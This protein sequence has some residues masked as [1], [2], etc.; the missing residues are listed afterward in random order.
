[1]SLDLKKLERARA[2]ADGV[3]QARCPACAKEG[4]DKAGEHLRVYSDGR[5]GCCVHPR[6]R[7]HRR[8]IHALAGD[9]E[10][11]AFR[12][13][14][15]APARPPLPLQSVTASLADF[16]R[17]LRTADSESVQKPQSPNNEVR[18]VRTPDAES[19]S[20]RQKVQE[21]FRTLRTGILRSRAY[22][23]EEN[24]HI[25]NGTHMCKDNE[26]GVLSVLSSQTGEKLP[27][28]LADGTLVI[29]FDSPE[30][31]HWWKSG[32]SVAETRREILERN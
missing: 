25:Y 32:Q 27:Y 29:P 21:E 17:T 16:S 7:E 3:I 18:T 4:G 15:T 24:T 6:D 12:V 10:R 23:R 28:L 20:N 30:R 11:R 8:Q 31:Y 19:E 1:M 5:F 13:H 26:R 9:K 14:V 2:L 22:A